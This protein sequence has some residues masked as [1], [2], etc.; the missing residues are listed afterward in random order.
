MS[1]HFL[2]QAALNGDRDHPSA[3]RTPESIAAEALAAVAAGAQSVH[4]HPYDTDGRETIDRVHCARTL[5]A[6]RAVCPGVPIS[7]S[8]SAAIEGDPE[9]RRRAIAAWTEM[10]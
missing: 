1:A 6:V 10:P 5:Q 7:L 9:R 4:L 2:L 8:T 3:P